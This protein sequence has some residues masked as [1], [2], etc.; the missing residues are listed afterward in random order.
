SRSPSDSDGYLLRKSIDDIT[1]RP[2]YMLPPLEGGVWDTVKTIA[3][4]KDEG[5]MSLW[6]GQFTNWLFDLLNDMFQ[7]SVESVI[8]ESF[9]LYDDTI[10]L[11][12]L[13]NPVP[14]LIAMV[15]SHA[16]VGV[17]LSPLE[18]VRTR[19]IIQP[20]SPHAHSSTKPQGFVSTL[21]SL[22]SHPSS[23]PYLQSHLL[24]PS[25][26]YHTVHPLIQLSL[27]LII[28][29]IFG[30]SPVYSPGRYMIL[31]LLGNIAEIGILLPIETVRRR[32]MVIEKSPQ[33]QET[34]KIGMSSCVDLRPIGYS[35]FWDC[36]FSIIREEGG[37]RTP[38]S[39]AVSSSTS[40][41]SRK[42]K[43]KSSRSAK[44]TGATMK[45]K[46]SWW[47]AG[48]EN[49]TRVGGLYKGFGM[50]AMT[51]LMV[52]V[53]SVVTGLEDDGDDF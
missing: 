19:L 3:K 20:T 34:Q 14:N 53:S 46:Q 32:L 10:P 37:T 18:I 4:H 26:L 23:N 42:G 21:R 11:I 51:T 43:R 28:D 33:I 8:S 45:E 30:V 47:K 17:A 41:R 13:D 25:I 22:F 7:P 9:D 49:V 52:F 2:S 24:I 31:E 38:R 16:I 5:Y 36:F 44:D 29:R 15:A 35:G 12:D 6:K 27:P 48:L 39:T 50:H 1:T 40:R